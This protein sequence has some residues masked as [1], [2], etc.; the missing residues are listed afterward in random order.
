M[1]RDRLQNATIRLV[2]AI[3]LA[4]TLSACGQSSPA[5]LDEATQKGDSSTITCLTPEEGCPCDAPGTIVDCGEVVR[6]TG[7]Y[8]SCSIGKRACNAGA[9]GAC[10]GDQ[11]STKSVTGGLHFNGLGG[12]TTCTDN[13]CD[14]Y[15]N[16]FIDDGSGLDAGDSG[17]AIS[18]GGVSLSGTLNAGSSCTSLVIT[19]TPQT[20]TVTKLSPVT[21][22]TLDF[23]AS[24]LPAGCYPGVVPALWSIDKY[25]LG[26]IDTTGLLNVVTPVAGPINVTAFAGTL[27]K[28]TAIANVVVKVVDI[29]GAP[30]G[31]T[32]ANFVSATPPADTIKIL[33]PYA[34][35]V[36]P[37]GLPPPLVQWD[38]NGA[39]AASAVK[40][41]LRYPA[42]GA[43][44]F[45]WSEIIAESTKATGTPTNTPTAQPRA[46]IPASVWFLFEQSAR[47]ND[48]VIAVQRIVGGVVKAEIPTTIHFADGQLKGT[49]LYQS[50]G[51]TLVTNFTGS[52]GNFGAATLSIKPGATAPT[53]AAGFT[54]AD[55]SGCRVCH[56]VAANGTKLITQHYSDSY[57]GAYDITVSPATETVMTLNT[58]YRY[59]WPALYPDGSFLYSN[60]GPSN[61]QDANTSLTSKLY[62]VPA[63]ST[64]GGT[65]NM[66]TTLQAATPTFSA[67]GKHI[68]FNFYTGTSSPLANAGPI[69]TGNGRTLAMMDYDSPTK[70]F[71]N[72]KNLHTPAGTTTDVWP[73]FLPPS[74]NGVVFERETVS[75]GAVAGSGHTDF[76]GTRSGCDGSGTCSND[77][78]KAELWWAGTG[79]TASPVP[80]VIANGGS[81]LPTG[82]NAHGNDAV[83]NYEPTVLPQSSGGYSW[84]VFTSRRLYGNVA[85]MNPWWSDPRYHDLRTDATPKKLWVTAVKNGAAIGSDPSAPAFYLPGQELLA[86]NSRGYWV[87][88]QC[89][90]AGP[91]LTAANLCDS[92]LDCCGAPTTSVCQLDPAPLANPP[93]SHCVG[94]TSGVCVPDNS[95]C[96]S[97]AQCCNFGSGSRCASGLCKAQPPFLYYTGTF[98]RDYV[99][100]CASGTRVAWRYF[101]WQAITPAGTS[102]N[103]KAQSADTAALLGAATPVVGVGNA[104]PPSTVTWTTGPQTVDAALLAAGGQSKAYLR[105]TA[106][107]N[108]SADNSLAPTLTN[109]REVYDCVPSE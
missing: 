65:V 13:P 32:D 66:P 14:P 62:T 64:I 85:T 2:G 77:G 33:Y 37:L 36:F 54:S 30:G 10:I 90:V 108:P 69:T 86:G 8:V 27:T 31:V 53:V 41:T 93:L 72:F 95:A 7:D 40:V 87:L 15:C 104:V 55:N 18:D 103:F 94:L 4:F 50:Y 68:A 23:N 70:T 45:S 105:V 47:A 96:T 56:S 38:L 67:D 29:S 75:D 79:A 51:T 48:A 60:A 61:L 5:V 84:V 91:P 101:S 16:N 11:I 100:S 82:V 74:E 1:K 19:P 22:A 35:T 57:S 102:I 39:A 20:L 97:D 28:A 80:L 49:V 6:R 88:Q 81:Y 76:G 46:V 12:S 73:S 106:T 34:Q 71:S 63:G 98:T 52:F 92:D 58:D 42:S 89:R 9:W 44:T 109:W 43:A 21:P 83:L 59:S 3:T 26:T 107:L 99:A 17:L 25:N 24:L 78:T